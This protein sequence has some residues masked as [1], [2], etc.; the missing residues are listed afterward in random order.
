[1]GPQR[2]LTRQALPSPGL[3][4]TLGASPRPQPGAPG[5]H[6][7]APLPCPHPTPAA[8]ASACPRHSAW[9]ARLLSFLGCPARLPYPAGVSAPPHHPRRA[10]WTFPETAAPG[11]LT[12]RAPAVEPGAGLA[13]GGAVVRTGQ[14]PGTELGT[15]PTGEGSHGTARSR[16][17][18][19]PRAGRQ[20][21]SGRR[22]SSWHL[23]GR[24]RRLARPPVQPPKIAA[25]RGTQTGSP[26]CPTPPGDSGCASQPAPA[27]TPACRPPE[28]S[29]G[30]ATGGRLWAGL[31]LRSAQRM[32]ARRTDSVQTPGTSVQGMRAGTSRGSL[33]G[34]GD[35]GGDG[36]LSGT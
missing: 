33:G 31:V 30:R 24:G 5:T 28:A 12:T 6:G 26:T 21:G 7:R 20:A 9:S 27:A 3:P 2:V 11:G 10:C 23:A 19:S 29:A 17:P 18:P 34:P 1:M 13:A 36:W 16:M 35:R 22:A 15:G 25:S 14:G 8:G 4:S 32:A